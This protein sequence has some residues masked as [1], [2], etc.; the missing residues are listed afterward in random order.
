QLQPAPP[1]PALAWRRRR[2]TRCWSGAGDRHTRPCGG[3]GTTATPRTSWGKDTFAAA[4][5]CRGP[6]TLGAPGTFWGKDT[7]AARR[8]CRGTGAPVTR[9]SRG[10]TRPAAAQPSRLSDLCA[11]GGRAG[12][13]AER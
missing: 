3:T 8:T 1:G 13:P 10:R 11:R 9:R 5:T 6:D 4:A 12:A 7:L 2:L